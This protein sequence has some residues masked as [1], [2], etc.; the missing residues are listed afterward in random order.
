MIFF[1][2]VLFP[3]GRAESGEDAAASDQASGFIRPLSLEFGRHPRGPRLRLNKE[4]TMC[5][6]AVLVLA[7][8]LAQG[9]LGIGPLYSGR[10][11]VSGRRMSALLEKAAR[12]CRR[13]DQAALDFICKEEIAEEIDH[14]WEWAAEK[15]FRVQRKEK[16]SYL[17]DIQFVRKNGIKKENRALLRRNG[18]AVLEKD[19]GAGVPRAIQVEYVLFGP[20]GL[21]GEAWQPLRRFRMTGEEESPDGERLVVVE[22]RMRPGTVKGHSD[23]TAWIRESDGAV[24][25]IEWDGTTAGGYEQIEERGRVF[26]AAPRLT[27][28]TEYGL[29]KNGLRFPSR[30]VTEEAYLKNGKKPFIRSRTE[31]RYTNY[32]FFTVETETD[33]GSSPS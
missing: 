2:M 12:Y 8:C 5:R 20:V 31:S 25:K 33:L 30:D 9:S 6:A 32:R 3:D 22:A 18:R 23:G 28:V 27:A 16:N 26:D 29:E 4:E 14:A 15:Y 24:L 21:L 17:Y 10:E 11:D 7:A 13:L 1:R 19:R